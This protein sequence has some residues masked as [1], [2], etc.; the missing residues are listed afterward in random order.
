MATRPRKQRHT[1]LA[2]VESKWWADKNTSVSGIFDL[3]SDIFLANPHHYHY[4]MISGKRAAK[5]AIPRIA[6]DPTCSI[7]YVAAHGEPDGVCWHNGEKLSRIEFRH[8]F[9]TI[10][11]TRGAQLSGI[12]FA[13]C[14]FM[15]KDTADYLFHENICPW[16]V[17]GYSNYVDWL[18]STALDM[19]FFRSL[20]MQ[21]KGTDLSRIK[22]VAADLLEKC[23]GLIR[24]LGFGIY[25]RKPGTGG[26]KNLLEAGPSMKS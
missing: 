8:I 21:R 15:N 23:P 17:A 2:V 24:E 26:A 13:C 20:M 22:A 4:E 18:D 10:R 5:E 11:E 7:L 19:L 9:K 16:W 6:A 12:H 14:T 3:I 1:G 25:I